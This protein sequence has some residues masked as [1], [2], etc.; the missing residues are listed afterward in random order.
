ML[1]AND[2]RAAELAQRFPGAR[3]SS[4]TSPTRPASRPRWRAGAPGSL[5]SVVH[6]AGVV[7]LGGG[8]TLAETWRLTLDVNLVAPAEITRLLLPAL[9]R[10]PRGTWCS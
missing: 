7:E 1:L 9:P 6:V 4:W 10:R 5:D 3:T 2:D 8:R